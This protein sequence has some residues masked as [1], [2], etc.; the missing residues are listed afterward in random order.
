M[1]E[2]MNTYNIFQGNQAQRKNAFD[3]NYGIFQGNEAGRERN[4]DRATGE[5]RTQHDIFKGNQA[6]IFNRLSS[7]SGEGQAGASFL[8]S[9]GGAY[10]RNAGNLTLEGALA[11][12]QYGI[13]GAGAT[14]GGITGGAQAK[15]GGV[16]NINSAI[17]TWMMMKQ[18]GLA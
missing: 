11:G 10:G 14:A 7:M 2:F 4:Y 15:I 9:Q 1:G 12:G 16:S 8:G 6:D 5:Y 3:T 17:Q 13:G 18:L